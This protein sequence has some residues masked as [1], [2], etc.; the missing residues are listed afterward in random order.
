M[1]TLFLLECAVRTCSSHTFSPKLRC[2]QD[3]DLAKA[4]N[5]AVL[6]LFI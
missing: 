6:V 5:M 1:K 3:A 4:S 2:A